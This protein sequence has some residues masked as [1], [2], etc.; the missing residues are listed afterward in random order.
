MTVDAKTKETLEDARR[1]IS[2]ALEEETINEYFFE[3]VGR[4]HKK[5]D[6][7]HDILHDILPD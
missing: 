4:A 5:L 3:Y 1:A 6:E 7:L 2:N